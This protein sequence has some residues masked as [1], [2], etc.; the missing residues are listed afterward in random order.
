LLLIGRRHIRD[1]NSWLHNLT[2]YARGK[3]RCTLLIN[4]Q[5][6]ERLGLRDSGMAAIQSR[7]GEFRAEVSIT[8]R[9]MP[10]VVSLPHGFGHNY[11]DTRQSVASSLTPGVSANDLV[12]DNEMDLPSGTSVVN[13][14]PV[15]V[16]PA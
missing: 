9:I 4:P 15:A 8:D 7:V 2:N 10:G 12:D 1:M 11:R 13:G 16:M 14:V 6:A 5:D 3:N